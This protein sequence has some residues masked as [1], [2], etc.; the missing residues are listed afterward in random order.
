MN[1]IKELLKELPLQFTVCFI[2]LVFLLFFAI[3]NTHAATINSYS[4]NNSGTYGYYDIIKS[5]QPTT[6]TYGQIGSSYNIWWFQAQANFSTSIN[7]GYYDLKINFTNSSF[8]TSYLG[9]VIVKAFTSKPSSINDSGTSLD[10]VYVK[11]NKSTNLTNSITI[12]FNNSLARNYTHFAVILVFGNDTSISQMNTGISSFDLESID[13]EQAIKDLQENQNT[14]RD[15]IIN[16]ITNSIDS[17]LNNCYSN[18]YSNYLS[19]SNLSF[20][21]GIFTQITADTKSELQ[22]KVQAYNNGTFV[23]DIISI[24]NNNISRLSMNFTKSNSFN[25]I[26]FGLNGSSR[27]TKL[28]IDVSNL[29]NDKSY[30]ISWNLLNNV[31]GSISFN[32]LMISDNGYINYVKSGEKFCTSKIDDLND[33]IK[34]TNDNIKDLDKNIKDTD[35][36]GANG[37]GKNFFDNFNTTD[38]GG[39]SGIISA[40]LRLIKGLVSSN[41]TNSCTDLPMTIMGKDVALPCGKILWSKVP[42]GTLTIYHTIICGFGAFAILR[43]LFKDIEDLKNPNNSEVKTTDL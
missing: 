8:N 18:Y 20:L 11:N 26:V 13:S 22:W 6:S 9:G 32:D 24:T 15:L 33:N 14:N 2:I 30:T 10:L 29:E 17:S 40:P 36:S 42:Q 5:G 7:S 3:S 27:D 39:I 23:K 43:A 4:F 35:T 37:K 16:N 31:Q 21:N 28:T 25:R 12:R 41:G 34:D 1:K 38:N 19:L